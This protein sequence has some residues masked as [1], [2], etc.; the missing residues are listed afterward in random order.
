M[1]IIK[2]PI[3]PQDSQ[4]ISR[5]AMYLF[6][7]SAARKM[8]NLSNRKGSRNPSGIFSNRTRNFRSPTRIARFNAVTRAMI[9]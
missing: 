5:P 8:Q 7:T 4:R 2:A 3:L 6:Y 1:L 9:L